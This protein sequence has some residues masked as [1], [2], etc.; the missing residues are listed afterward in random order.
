[1]RE[2]QVSPR[3]LS[4]I[5]LAAA[6]FAGTAIVPVIAGAAPADE[7]YCLKLP[8]AAGEE[9]KPE[10]ASDPTAPAPSAPIDPTEGALAPTET[11]AHGA[12]V[13]EPTHKGRPE[14]RG[15][16][17]TSQPMGRLDLAAPGSDPLLDGPMLALLGGLVLITSTGVWA[18]LRRRRRLSAAT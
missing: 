14:D 18:A 11:A 16:F 2:R 1:M 6:L 3:P 17:T 13:S 8:N 5:V 10:G 7:E 12:Q 15:P 9:C 4:I